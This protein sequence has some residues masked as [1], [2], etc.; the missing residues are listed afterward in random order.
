MVRGGL[1]SRLADLP[2]KIE[3]LAL[4]PHAITTAS[5][6]TRRTTVVRL[7]GEGV[8][9]QGEDVTYQDVDQER[10]QANG[11]RLP[12]T[13]TF[14]IDTFS[15]HIDRLDL[16]FGEP[17]DPKARDHRIWAFESAA[18]DLALR[19]AGASLSDALD[20]PLRPLRFVASL[21]LGSPPSLAPLERLRRRSPGLGFKV[22]FDVAWTEAT[23]SELAAFGGV[24]AVD[25]KGLYRGSF[26]GPP[27]DARLYRL[28]AERL[29]SAWIE[30]PEWNDETSQALAPHVERVSWD[31]PIHSV[32]DLLARP[33][34]GR[35]ASIK[36]SRFG[37]WERLFAMYEH[38]EAR[39]IAMYSGGQFELG[40][41]RDQIQ[42]LAAMFHPDAPNDCAPRVF[43]TAD[44]PQRLPVSPLAVAPAPA[45]FALAVP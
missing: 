27:A 7:D 14:T 23:L 44:P 37:S 21:G 28:V 18:A 10:F 1:Y 38:C 20:R 36:P 34:Q 24:D 39:G 35:A 3:G 31:A 12:V 40:I 2:A 11:A 22:D 8:A 41:G 17:A 42:Y 13:G 33:V 45:G 16:F 4:E 25:L 6:W 9:G 26:Q 32:N 30:D 43:N 5:G 15:R 19:Q 29:P